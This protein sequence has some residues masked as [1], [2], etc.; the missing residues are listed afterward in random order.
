VDQPNG[1]QLNVDQPN[2]DQPDV[3]QPDVDQPDVDQ[4]NVVQPN[5]V[6]PDV[7]QPKVD[8][9]NVVQPDVDQPNVVQPNV[10]QLNVGQPNVVQPNVGQPNVDRLQMIQG[11]IT[12]L[13]TNSGTFKGFAV[14][15]VTALLGVGIDKNNDGFVW[16][17]IYP[18]AVFGF[19]DAYY[20]ALEKRYRA[21]YKKATTDPDTEWSLSAGQA[22]FTEILDSWKSPSVWAFYGAALAVVI[23]VALIR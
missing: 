17:G 14:P 9:P 16:L 11:V 12:R 2:V 13:A 3:D 4:P 10:G 15:V 1:D 19:L 21:L 22:T 6:Q 7:D 18:I 20:L 23:A 8:Q 5:V